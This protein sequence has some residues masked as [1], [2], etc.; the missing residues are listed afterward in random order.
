MLWQARFGKDKSSEKRCV[1]ELEF[2][3]VHGRWP[4]LGN[5][6]N[7]GPAWT[8][9]PAVAFGGPDDVRETAA[10]RGLEREIKKERP[11]KITNFL[12]ASSSTIWEK[13]DVIQRICHTREPLLHLVYEWKLMCF[14][15]LRLR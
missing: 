10:K 7:Q 12:L 2:F 9:I 14:E 5:G 15:L 6:G 11:R 4:E 3:C 13:P 1:P 8:K